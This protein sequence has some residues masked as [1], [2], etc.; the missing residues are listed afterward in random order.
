MKRNKFRCI[1][2]YF[3]TC[4]EKN[5]ILKLESNIQMFTFYNGT[6]RVVCATSGKWFKT[7]ENVILSVYCCPNRRKCE[8]Q[9]CTS[10][11]QYFS[12]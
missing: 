2:S 10:C 12:R 1:T 3:H 7:V 4:G 11:T 9:F 5:P 6:N 8:V